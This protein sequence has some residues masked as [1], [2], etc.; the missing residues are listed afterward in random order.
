M[1]TT[2]VAIATMTAANNTMIA[3]S[4]THCHE[5]HPDDGLVLL[6]FTL[7]LLIPSILW[8]VYTSIK[9]LI[10]KDPYYDF[11]NRNMIALY[12]IFVIGGLGLLTLFAGFI[13]MLIK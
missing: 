1:G 8:I 3:N 7:A 2:A 6:S 13:Y 12:I 11:M 5:S 4:H 10:K 9:Q